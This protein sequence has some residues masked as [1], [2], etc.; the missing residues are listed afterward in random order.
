MHNTIAVA[1]SGG[2]DSSVAAWL[3]RQEG[4]ETAGVTLRL[5]Q[6]EDLAP[7]RGEACHALQDEEDARAVA[8]QLGSPPY[9]LDLSDR[10][11]PCVM[12]PLSADYE[13]GRSPNL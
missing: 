8:A 3:L 4:W 10:F 12:D 7:G 13:E 2:V 11:A 6:P 9:T 5:F 1:M